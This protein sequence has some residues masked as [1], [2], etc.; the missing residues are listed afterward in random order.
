[1][2]YSDVDKSIIQQCNAALSSFYHK[3]YLTV[4]SY[5]CIAKQNLK[6]NQ[7]CKKLAEVRGRCASTL[8][9][10]QRGNYAAN[11]PSPRALA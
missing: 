9:A 7:F 5:I 4:N 11:S 1:M 10:R 3:F 8:K 6:P 2:F